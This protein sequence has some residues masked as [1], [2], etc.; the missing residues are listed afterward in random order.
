[1]LAVRG[2]H[3]RYGRVTAVRAAALT[4]ERG[5]L[6][7]IVGPNG[8]GKTSILRAITGLVPAAAGTVQ[9]DGAP[10]T[11]R[12]PEDIVRLGVVMVPEGRE[13]FGALSVRD[14][15]RLGAYSTPRAG[16]A[17]RIA[18]DLDRVV[19][20]FPALRPRLE[21]AAATLSGGE[22]QMV[23]I[24]RALMAR[25]RLL[26]LDEPSVGLAPLVVRDIFAVLAR[27][28]AEG[29]TM[30]LVEQNARAAFR[31]A[32]RGYALAPGGR[33][34]PTATGDGTGAARAAYGLNPLAEESRR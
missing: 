28:K 2:L 33:L 3:V 5:E 26:V 6:V 17:R 15:L 24:G 9:L 7:T 14:N 13:L 23:A 32:D 12:A 16:R 22:Q 25:P 21:R 8:A 1:M 4:V 20:L 18:A 34:V 19:A 27:L 29:L 11:T 31:I 30:L 10:I